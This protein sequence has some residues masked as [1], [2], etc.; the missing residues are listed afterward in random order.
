MAERSK[1]LRSGRSPLLW[2]WYGAS[3]A[4][5]FL[6]FTCHFGVKDFSNGILE[7]ESENIFIETWPYILLALK[8]ELIV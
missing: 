6:M 2:A 1:A 4:C 8:V 5:H 7:D 3:P